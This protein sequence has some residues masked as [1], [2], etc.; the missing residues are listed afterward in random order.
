MKGL[1]GFIFATSLLS[2][3]TECLQLQRRSDGPARVVGLP[4]ERKFIEDPVKR[5]RLRRRAGTVQASLD[6][7]VWMLVLFVSSIIY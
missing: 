7:E 5:D 1:S 4:I 6:N 2:T 3:C